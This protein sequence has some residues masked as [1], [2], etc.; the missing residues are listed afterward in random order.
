MTWLQ[1]RAP[2]EQLEDGRWQVTARCRS[3]QVEMKLISEEEPNDNARAVAAAQ[4]ICDPCEDTIEAAEEATRHQE[5]LRKR[6][7]RSNLPDDLRGFYFNEM[8][9]DGGR[10]FVVDA[11][12][13]WSEYKDPEPPAICLF[14]GKGRGKTRLAATAAAAR[15]A[16]HDVRWVSMPILLAQLGAAFSDSARRQAIA[17]LTGKGALIIDDLDKATP[18]DWAATQIFAALDTRIQA[19][20]PLLITTNL[21][22]ARLGEKF[23]GEI[24]EAIMSRIGGMRVLELPGRDNRLTLP[25]AENPIPEPQ[26]GEYLTD[27]DEQGEPDADQ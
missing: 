27:P 22:P 21:T 24:G 3:C 8:L 6:L 25:V 10:R 20:A 26:P 23:K 4:S 14:G 15:L 16:R 12:R 19:G 13:H 2:V 1:D 9:P 18:S 17:V 7:E 11:V 5:A